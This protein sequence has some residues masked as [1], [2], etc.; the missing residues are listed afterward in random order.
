MSLSVPCVK[1]TYALRVVSSTA[2]CS[3][4]GMQLTVR[5]DC[6]T[7]ANTRATACRNG[8]CAVLSCKDGYVVSPDLKLCVRPEEL[9]RLVVQ[10]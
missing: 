8:S 1:G 10:S 5:Q 4:L 2:G 7:I 6:S 3:I 9:D